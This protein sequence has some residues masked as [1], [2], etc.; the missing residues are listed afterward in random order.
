M[1]REMSIKR[2]YSPSVQSNCVYIHITPIDFELDADVVSSANG[3]TAGRHK[4]AAS[5]HDD[6]RV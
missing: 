5:S 6:F 3:H 1:S 4:N 2:G